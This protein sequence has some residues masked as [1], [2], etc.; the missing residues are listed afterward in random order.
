MLIR[1]QFPAL[2]LQDDGKPRLYFDNPGGTQ[3][4]NQVLIRMQHYLIRTNANHGGHFRTSQLSDGILQEAH[5]AM[6]DL[7]NAGSGKEII[8]GPN[9]T[10]LTFAISRSLAHWFKPGDEIILTRMD[11]DGNVMPWLLMARDLNI[12]VKWLDFDPETC[13]YDLQQLP[14]LLSDKVRL[15]AVNYAS[16]A[17]GTINDIAAISKL[18]RVNGS[19]TYVDAVQYVP[20]GP[21]D[22]Q[23]LGC[24]FLVCSAYKFFGPHQGVLWGKPELLEKLPAYKVRPADDVPPGKFETGTQ[25]HEGQAGTL[26]A[27]DYLAWIGKTMAQEYHQR[28]KF[29]NSRRQLLHAALAAIKDYEL[30]LSRKLIQGLQAIPGV[31]VHG[32]T[33]AAQLNDRVPT[34]SFT[35]DGMTPSLIAKKLGQQNIYVWDGHYY[36]LEVIKKLGLQEDEGM[37]RV[38]AVHY[39]T[40]EE[41]DRLLGM[42]QQITSENKK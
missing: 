42:L 21:T 22:V 29:P 33:D 25:S 13:R 6:A 20:H 8:F 28:F 2:A 1:Q 7:L 11:H 37:V 39:N 3:V 15:M 26:G 30:I 17:I 9:M 5:E 4:P 31:T 16:N 40:T 41:I 32:I 35:V 19:L 14:G 10:S 34:V 36:A 18:A 12:K 23:A 27:L 38:G 24:D